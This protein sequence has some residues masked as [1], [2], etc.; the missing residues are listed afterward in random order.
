[1]K[2]DIRWWHVIALLILIA[3]G[4][5]TIWSAQQQDQSVR[6]DLLVKTNIAKTGVSTEY[7]KALKGS[8]ADIASPE[9]QAL[10]AQLKNIR[11]ADPDIRFAYIVGQTQDGT[12]IIYADSES[13]ESADY[14]PPG[15]VY[16]EAPAV[17]KSIFKTGG[18]ANEG[19]YTDRWGTW[20]SGFIPIID[21]ATGKVIAIFG[22]DV[23]AQNWNS[24]IVQAC[25]ATIAA[26]LLVLVI[27]VAFGLIQQ[28]SLVEQRLIATSEE[29]FSKAFHTNPALMV[30]S[31]IEE[32]RILDVNTSF[33]T[34]FGYSR[35]EVIGKTTTELELFFDP[36][37]R[38][39]ILHQIKETGYI[40]DME[41][42]F[43][44]K[45]QDLL[46]GSLTSITVDVAG[47][48]RLLTFILDL[49]DRKRAEAELIESRERFRQL[50]EVFP[51]TIF[52]AD[53][54]GYVTYAN[55]HGLEQFGFTEEDISNRINI[56]NLVLPEDR[57]KV[58]NSVQ[59]N[60]QGFNT[61]YLECQVLRKDG[62]AFWVL[63]LL[64]PIMVNGIR[65]GIRGFILDITP[66]KLAEDQQFK[67]LHERQIILDNA[68]IGIFMISDR[69][70]IWVNQKTEEIFQYTKE[71]L[72]GQT[73]RKLYPSQAEYEQLGR[74]SYPILTQGHTYE[75]E[76]KLIRRDETPIWVRCHAKA[77]EPSDI[78]KGIIWLLEDITENKRAEEALRQANKKL[79]L[80]SSITRH[81]IN[82]QLT[83]ILGYMDML[84]CKEHD[85]I[86]D[87][88]FQTVT[89]A[90]QRI[91]GM[92]RFT[93]EYESIGIN[94]PFWQDC[95]TL[96]ATAA[97]EAPLGKV[98]LKNDLPAGTEV[99]ADPLIVKV[100]Y[101]LMDNAVRYGGKITTIR[102]YV[103]E[104]DGEHVV[105]C[106]DDGDGVPAQD[107]EK[108]FER[109][110][111]RNTGLGL[112]LSKEILDITGITIS[113]TG[114]PGKGARFEIVVPKGVYRYIGV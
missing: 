56:F 45:N 71:E 77:I 73:T 113:E 28:R 15:Q 85:P 82:N 19:P 36:T 74:D 90:A 86:L 106:E 75:T 72:V 105:V 51:E 59:R 38:N 11:A 9:Y 62:S 103:K 112:A 101:N 95:R 78:S 87:E 70:L 92:I 43:F 39:S 61:E 41:V 23:D 108:I 34:T 114:E 79:N 17:L 64:V 68:D 6:N 107:K 65:V 7:F 53:V 20:V 30:V 58:L 102:F 93:K 104:R 16:A 31:T 42:R 18:M 83:V 80:L 57:D 25:A 81:D 37:L 49:T 29:K 76:Q 8:A 60:S 5:L 33:L 50:S 40:R 47:I 4:I 13:P 27:I 94:A 10:K 32:G 88:Y 14:S 84:D 97:N 98:M 55:K 54:D 111:G 3:G 99:F 26:S 91:A 2:R 63:G 52:E 100:F 44:R 24:S 96:L 22:M 66:R 12:I 110:F 67:I 35:K 69:K 46:D 109:G 89:I 21:P 48:P 1:M